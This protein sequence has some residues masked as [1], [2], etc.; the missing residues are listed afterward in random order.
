MLS[1]NEKSILRCPLLK[2]EMEIE[3]SLVDYRNQYFISRDYD[4]IL[5]FYSGF[6][7]REQLIEWMKARPKGSNVIHE[8]EGDKEVIVVIPT[9]NINGEYAKECRDNIFKGLHIVFVES[10]KGNFYFN[11]AQNCNAGIRKAMEHRPKWII[12][13]NDDVK[14]ID[15]IHILKKCLNN[16][17]EKRIDAVFTR[18]SPDGYHSMKRYLG[19]PSILGN[20]YYKVGNILN[21][22]PFNFWVYMERRH[23]LIEKFRIRTILLPYHPISR[24]L[25]KKL[26]LFSL[27][28]AF[29]IFSSSFVQGRNL[30]VFDETYVNGAEDWEISYELSMNPDKIAFI[31]YLI[32]E[33][34]GGTLGSSSSKAGRARA[35]RDVANICLFNYYHYNDFK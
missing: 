10:G 15:E 35:L 22:F 5:E 12:V 26:H 21:Y 11:Y 25:F 16:L 3:F 6:E 33:D 4:K 20:I 31:D 34:V 19:A 9:S 2:R 30:E 1:A 24:I 28:A 18:E 8:I 29:S 17:D 23:N 13:S 27:T 7:S 32:G 14:K